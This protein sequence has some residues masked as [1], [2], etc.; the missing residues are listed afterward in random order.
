MHRIKLL[1]LQPDFNVR[2]DNAADLAE[3]IVIGLPSSQFEVTS[4]YLSGKPSNAQPISV[5]SKSYYFDIPTEDL[6]GM[7][8]KALWKVF[9]FCKKNKFDVIICNR[10]KTVSVLLLLNTFIRA[11]LC[12]GI[13]HITDE[14]HRT[15]RRWQVNTFADKRWQFIGVSNAVK[16][17]MLKHGK[18]FA[19]SNTHAIV[20]GIDV[21]GVESRLLDKATVRQKLMLPANATIIGAIGRLASSKG[22][23]YLIEALANLKNKFPDTHIGIIGTGAEKTNLEARA[24]A[25]GLS[26]R[27]HLLGFVE[28]AIQYVKG[29]DIWTMP[30]VREGLGLALLEGMAGGL[31]VIASDLP[32][33]Q[34]LIDGAGGLKVRPKSIEDLTQALDTYL[35]MS[36]T[37]RARHGEVAYQYV[38]THH[39]IVTYRKNYCD[40][41]LRHLRRD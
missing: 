2:S 38:K 11:P 31:P 39:N 20:N 29:F 16:D 25:L 15:Y 22:H 21:E 4:A 23:I 1:Q 33:M 36:H 32:A 6:N 8:I 19:L 28:N 35:S 7:R 14:Y 30:S 27:V 18:G 9:W 13:S 26:N 3:Q 41:I 10:F 5:A 34:P 12:I 24:E 37:E 40:F 17:S